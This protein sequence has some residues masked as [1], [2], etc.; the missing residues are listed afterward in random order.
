MR[1][2]FWFLVSGSLLL[3]AG[4]GLLVVGLRHAVCGQ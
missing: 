1:I 4:Y 3:V 2:G